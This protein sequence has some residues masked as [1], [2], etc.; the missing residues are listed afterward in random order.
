MV[1]ENRTLDIMKV[2]I[3]KAHKPLAGK[4]PRAKIF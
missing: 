2:F 3:A 1:V 4:P